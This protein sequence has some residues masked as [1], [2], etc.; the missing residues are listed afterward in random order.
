[1]RC[2]DCDAIHPV[3]VGCV[4]EGGSVVNSAQF[5]VAPHWGILVFDE[6]A[7]SDGYGGTARH[8][9]ANYLPFFSESAWNKKIVE[10]SLTTNPYNRKKFVA[11]KASGKA[12]IEPTFNVNVGDL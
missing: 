7:H 10:L 5:P 1:M 3:E 8:N 2:K 9:Y 4:R 6:V 11:F 12:K